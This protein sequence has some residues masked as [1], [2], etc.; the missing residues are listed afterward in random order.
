MEW[1]EAIK[2]FKEISQA[3]RKCQFDDMHWDNAKPFYLHLARS[4]LTQRLRIGGNFAIAQAVTSR[5]IRD[6]IRQIL[7]DCIFITLTL[8]K[9]A[10]RER[11]LARHGKAPPEGI[12]T[13]MQ[14]MY[15]LYELPGAC[16]K[17]TYNVDIS[18]GMKPQ[19]V[20]NKV[21]EVLEENVLTL[22]CQS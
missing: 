22:M 2:D 16:E 19:D 18:E 13:V 3:I 20:M 7:P 21:L 5:D 9:E 4:I 14:S 17:N 15:D 12:L 6:C 10:Q 11:L 1:I 8:T